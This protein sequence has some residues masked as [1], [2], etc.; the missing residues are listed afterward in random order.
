M[1]DLDSLA[2]HGAA[3]FAGVALHIFLFR[4]GE[5][6]L[7]ATKLLVSFVT[8]Y[9]AS[10]AGLVYWLP[11]RYPTYNVAF[12]TASGLALY[13]ILGLLLSMLVY[14]GFFHRLN[15]FPGPFV[16]RLSN[17]YPTML[18]A[19]KFHL[20]EEVQRLHQQYGDFVRLGKVLGVS[21]IFEDTC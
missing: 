6:D 1:I 12:G 11:A 4:V 13:F 21:D 10:V 3:F 8:L 15:R 2:A 20:Y 9:I 16:A 5:W 17:L 18:S 14:R 19:K 7:A